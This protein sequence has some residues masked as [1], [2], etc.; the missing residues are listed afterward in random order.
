LV[1]AAKDGTDFVHLV[2]VARGNH[3][4]RHARTITAGFLFGDVSEPGHPAIFHTAQ[5]DPGHQIGLP[6]RTF[7]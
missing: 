5:L 3:D 4:G 1:T 2:G 7:L 6:V